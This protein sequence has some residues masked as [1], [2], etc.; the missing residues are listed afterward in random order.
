VEAVTLFGWRLVRAREAD[1]CIARLNAS[2][3]YPLYERKGD[4]VT[5]PEISN[6]FVSVHNNVVQRTIDVLCGKP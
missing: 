1:W 2:A 4:V 5:M 3:V 6:V